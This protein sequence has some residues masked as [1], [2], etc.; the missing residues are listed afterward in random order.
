MYNN[1]NSNCRLLLKS[2][3]REETVTILFYKHIDITGKNKEEEEE[4]EEEKKKAFEGENVSFQLIGRNIIMF[5][6]MLQHTKKQKH[7]NKIA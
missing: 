1:N 6:S 4:E 2:L 3:K 5:S 7:K